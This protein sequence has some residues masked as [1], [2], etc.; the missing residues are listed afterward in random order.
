MQ[1]LWPAA[2]PYPLTEAELVETYAPRDRAQ[3]WLRVNFVSSADGAVALDGRSAGLSSGA[4][5]RVFG[6]LRM[7]CDVL[8]VGAGTVRDESYGPLQVDPRRRAWRRDAGLAEW[9]TLAVVSGRLGITPEH[10]ALAEAP[11]RPIVITHQRSP[12]DRREALTAVAD[13]VTV[14]E[15]EVDLPAARR[16]LAD[17]GLRQVLC[18]GGPHLLAALLAADQVDELCLTISPLLTGPGEGRIVA[19]PATPPRRLRLAGA[20]EADGN[21]VLRYTRTTESD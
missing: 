14:G 20:I 19:G 13:V 8:L 1:R 9:P 12:V 6:I 21:L 18:E 17:R 11:V 2:T 15:S 10:P 7:H 16:A 4:D 5:K 3:P